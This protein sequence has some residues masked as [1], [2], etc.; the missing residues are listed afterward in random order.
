MP[1]LE[2]LDIITVHML[3]LGK[4]AIPIVGCD[5]MDGI[6]GFIFQLLN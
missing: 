3:D 5:S 1:G 2:L 6:S 4:T